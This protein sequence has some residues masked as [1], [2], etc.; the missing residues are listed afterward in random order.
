VGYR[1][2]EELA[3]IGATEAVGRTP[4][5]S[6]TITVDGTT[7]TEATFE[8]DLTTLQSDDDR[9]D[10]QLRRQAL[11]TGQFP[12]ASFTLTQPI[13]LGAEPAEGAV[14]EVTAAGDLTLHGTTNAVE[15][16]MQAK[17][18]GG[19][20]TVVGSLPI[21]FADYGIAKPQSMIVLSV[22]DNGVMEFQLHFS[23][24]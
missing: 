24:G 16:P 3:S 20:V 4:D 23:R 12:T 17:L 14:L 19:V 9:R 18:E 10:G 1:V 5:V 22:E 21:A 11:E 13:E 15:I 8:A 2:R 6:G 7:I